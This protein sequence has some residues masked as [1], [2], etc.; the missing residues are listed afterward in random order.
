[1][2]AQQVYALRQRHGLS[3]A[4]FARVVY[5]TVRTVRKWEAGSAVPCPARFELAAIK[6][7]DQIALEQVGVAK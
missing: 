2:T 6:L 4:E 5:T 3:L 7:S 1:M